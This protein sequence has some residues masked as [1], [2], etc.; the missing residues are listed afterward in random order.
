MRD[1]QMTRTTQVTAAS[2]LLLLA[3]SLASS[4]SPSQKKPETF[5][6]FWKEFTA[7][8]AKNDKE[9]VAALTQLPF[10]FDNKN[11]D[12]AGFIRIYNQVFTRSVRRCMATAKPLRNP[13]DNSYDVFCGELIFS[14]GKVGRKFRFVAY[15]P[16]D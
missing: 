1:K 6:S 2:M 15:G 7:A 11:Q 4:H 8:L 14:F 13:S 9:T 5:T 16:N 3:F 10:Y 12:R